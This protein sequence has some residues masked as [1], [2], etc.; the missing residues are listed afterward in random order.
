M[1]AGRGRPLERLDRLVE[2]GEDVRLAV[3]ADPGD[4]ALQVG[5]AA[6]RLGPDDPVRG[7]VEADDPELV[8]LGQGRGGPQDRLLADVD[9]LDAADPA[10]AAHPALV[11]RVAVAGRHRA[12]LVDDDDERDVGLLLPV[13]HAHVDR[14]RLLERRLLVAA[15][16]VA[17]RVRRS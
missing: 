17:L 9:L 3:G 11:E 5:D 14:Q 16:A 1:A 15:G 4:L 2:P 6:E 13:A 10:A 12:R 8:A 7:L